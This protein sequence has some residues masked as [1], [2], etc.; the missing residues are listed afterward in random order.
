MAEAFITPDMLRWARRRSLGSLEEAAERLNI[1]LEKLDAWEKGEA[2]PT[3]KQAQSLAKKLRI[4]FGYLY[5]SNPP[6]ETMPLP[7]LRTKPG[8]PQRKPSPDFL[9]VLYDALRKQEWYHDYLASEQA[10]PISFVG[11]FNIQSPTMVVAQDIRQTLRMDDALRA[12]GQTRDSYFLQLVKHAE[13][14]GIIVLRNSVVG[15][16]TYRSLDPDEFQGF[17]ISDDLAPV[18]F[19]NQNDFLSAQ[20]FTF[21]HELA[22]IWIGLS[23]IS[24]PEYLAKAE[25]QPHSDE[26]VTNAVAAEVLVPASSFNMQWEAHSGLDTNLDKL[27]RY[28][29]V[30]AFVVLRRAY[31]LNMLSLYEFQSKYTELS[32]KTLTKKKSGGGWG[33]WECVLQE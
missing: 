2:R 29:R 17:A 20:I 14:S 30:S 25:Q 11:R 6:N 23:G 8:T 27:A 15:N 21:A 32:N 33:V 19:I 12:P 16:N 18:I 28:Y 22:H 31:E 4:P 1:K 9:D 3:F 13:D 24:N 26:Q 7:D 5:L 10:D